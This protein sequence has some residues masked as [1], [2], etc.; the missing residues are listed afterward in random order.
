MYVI[1]GQGKC[2]RSS[3]GC[4]HRRVHRPVFSGTAL[5]Q[6][7]A[8]DRPRLSSLC[9]RGRCSTMVRFFWLASPGRGSR[10][11]HHARQPTAVLRRADAPRDAEGRGPVA[12]LGGF[13]LPSLLR[14]EEAEAHGRAGQG[15][16]RHP[17]L[18]A[19]RGARRRTCSTSSPTR[20]PRSAASSSRSPRTCP[21]SRSASTCR[22][23][24]GGCTRR[25]SSA[26][27]TTRPAATTRCP[28]TP[29]TRSRCPTSPSTQRHLSAQH[30]LGLRVPAAG[31]SA[32]HLPA[33]VY[34][35]CY[36]GWGQSIRRPGPYAGFLGKRY[37]PLFTECSPY[38][39]KDARRTGRAIRRSCAASRRLPDSTPGRRHHAR[40]PPRPPRACSQQFDDQVAP[41]ERQPRA[42]RR[43]TAASSGPSSLLTSPKV[44]AAFDLDDE[45]P[46][47]ARPLRP[48]AVRLQHADRPP[49]GRGG[50]ALRQRDLGLLLGALQLNYDCWDT[51]TRNFPIL[52]RVQPAPPRPDALGAC[53]KTST[54]AACSTRRWWW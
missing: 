1:S 12:W 10:D 8:I 15:E 38:V 4:E 19:R 7:F 49:A 39:D 52:P 43:S 47:A 16:E 48:H 23:R 17:A 34:L 30:G 51:H 45:D 50:R 2:L 44:K 27:S 33:Y 25:R 21:A 29:A 11:D 37:D 53:W 54:A 22:G 5:L 13:N 18:P 32:T 31:R 9:W 3:T 24:P 28:A 42:R 40:P 20:P 46:Q 26:R 41:R 36:L 14:A 35:P 6:I